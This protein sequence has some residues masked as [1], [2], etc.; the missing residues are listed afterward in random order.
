MHTP[1][2]FKSESLLKMVSPLAHQGR[3]EGEKGI[4]ALESSY[5]VFPG[6]H[7]FREKFLQLMYLDMVSRNLS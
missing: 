7:G 4:T 5:S 1:P 6:N 2:S 3:C